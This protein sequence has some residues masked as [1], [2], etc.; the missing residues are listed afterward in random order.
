M[1]NWANEWT[2][3]ATTNKWTN[4]DKSKALQLFQNYFN[5]VN[6][7]REKRILKSENR[8]RKAKLLWKAFKELKCKSI[9]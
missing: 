5:E 6:E 7:Q 8:R 1:E 9:D 3:E 4:N 2:N